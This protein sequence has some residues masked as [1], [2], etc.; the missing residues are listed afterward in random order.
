MGINAVGMTW[1]SSFSSSSDPSV[2]RAKDAEEKRGKRDG[3][4]RVIVHH[5]VRG[6]DEAEGN[7]SGRC[8]RGGFVSFRRGSV[9]RRK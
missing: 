2:V 6:C 3:M 8:R 9:Y 5:D 4:L 7:D 1:A